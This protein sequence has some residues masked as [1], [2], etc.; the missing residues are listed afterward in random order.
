MHHAAHPDIALHREMV[1]L[2]GSGDQSELCS[3]MV[4]ENT[5]HTT[6]KSPRVPVV[7]Y[8]QRGGPE[9]GRV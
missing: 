2:E 1:H 3:F 4:M 5:S 9:M 7:D 8:K 6:P